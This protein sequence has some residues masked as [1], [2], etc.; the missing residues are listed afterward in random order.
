MAVKESITITRIYHCVY[1]GC[2]PACT[3]ARVRI[4]HAVGEVGV[5]RGCGKGVGMNPSRMHSC[6]GNSSRTR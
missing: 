6:F 2:I 1:R 3:W 4:R 5:N